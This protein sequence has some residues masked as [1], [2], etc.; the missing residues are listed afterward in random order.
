MDIA[1]FDD[2]ILA[3]RSQ[4]E[5]QRLLLVFAGSELPG[6]STPA[7]REAF[8]QGRGGVLV[9]LM[10]VDKLPEEL[11]SFAALEEESAQFAKDWL[12][13]FAA[14]FPLAHA[15]TSEAAEAPL[16]AM[17]QAI[18]RGDHAS[19]ISFDRSGEVVELQ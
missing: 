10:S 15:P 9:P 3:A 2:L 7:Q 14:G 11:T 19:F 6:D 17:V 4:A 13:V 12:L 1:S 8:E 16:Q 18:H 5:P